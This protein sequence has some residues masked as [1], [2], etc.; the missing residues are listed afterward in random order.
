MEFEWDEAKR[1]ANI[2]KHGIDFIDAL[3]VFNGDTVTVEDD[4]Y[5][6]GEQRFVTFGLLQGRVIAVVYTERSNRT[7]II[8][9]RK[10]TN[11]E[12]RTYFEQISN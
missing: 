8:S 2:R 4:R 10:A 3:S 9:A 1:L 7:R 5:D 11:Y 6:Y 12:Q